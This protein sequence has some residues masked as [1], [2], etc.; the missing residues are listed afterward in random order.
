MALSHSTFEDGSTLWLVVGDFSDVKSSVKS[1]SDNQPSLA[2]HRAYEIRTLSDRFQGAGTYPGQRHLNKSAV[3]LAIGLGA[4]LL[5]LSL[6]INRQTFSWLSIVPVLLTW[7][8]LYVFTRY[9]LFRPPSRPFVVSHP[10]KSESPQNRL[11]D[12]LQVVLAVISLAIAVWTLYHT[13][14]PPS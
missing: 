10:A 2:Q 6:L 3:A 13:Y 14:Q 9:L 5:A 12:W 4:V 7:L 8:A 1:S 11:P